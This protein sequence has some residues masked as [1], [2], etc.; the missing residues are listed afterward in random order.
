[1]SVFEIP[2]TVQLIKKKKLYAVYKDKIHRTW[3]LSLFLNLTMPQTTSSASENP[4]NV[5]GPRKC[6]PTEQVLDNSD[7]LVQ[8]KKKKANTAVNAVS[9]SGTQ[10]PLNNLLA[11]KS[12]LTHRASVEDITEPA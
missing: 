11:I 5:H 8:K 7:P 9:Y 6:R 12:F 2:K 3:S 4:L 10:T 1:V